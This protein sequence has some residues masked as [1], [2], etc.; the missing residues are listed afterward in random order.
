MGE[1]G[2]DLSRLCE[3]AASPGLESGGFERVEARVVPDQRLRDLADGADGCGPP[4]H[5]DVPGDGTLADG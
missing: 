2:E 5:V 3:A 4:L 1:V